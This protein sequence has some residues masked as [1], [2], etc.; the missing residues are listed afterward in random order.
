MKPSVPK[1]LTPRQKQLCRALDRLTGEHG[2]A[3]S[4]KELAGELKVSVTRCHA[5]LR[6]T[7]TKGAIASTPGVARSWRTVR[8]DRRKR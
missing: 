2:Y 3:P 8:S 6:S 7:A 5:L 4:V 1:Q